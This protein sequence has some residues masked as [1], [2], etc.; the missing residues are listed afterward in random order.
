MPLFHVHGLVASTLST[1]ASG[2]TVVIPARFAAARFWKDVAR[3]D[4]TWSSAV[5]TIWRGAGRRTR[6]PSGPVPEHRLRFARSCSSA[7]PTA[8]MATFEESFG[9]PLVEAYGMTEAAHQMARNPL[10]PGERRPGSVGLATGIEIGDRST[11]TGTC[12][13][14][15]T[16]GEVAVRGPSVVD[17]LPREPGGQR[18]RVPRRL[19]PHRRPRRARRRTAT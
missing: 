9:V 11:T 14:P 13:A 3:W 6:P 15:A 17:E 18:G 2:G 19:V 5:P 10:P 7:L 1:L 16:S 8:L 4:A 12:S